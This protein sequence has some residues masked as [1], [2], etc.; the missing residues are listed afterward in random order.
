MDPTAGIW[1][2]CGSDGSTAAPNNDLAALPYG[3]YLLEE[4]PCDTNKGYDLFSDVIDINHDPSEP[5]VVSKTVT[6]RLIEESDD[7][8]ENDAKETKESKT[9]KDAAGK[10]AET[11]DWAALPT[12]QLLGAAA[13]AALALVAARVKGGNQAQGGRYQRRRRRK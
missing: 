5:S 1:F 13:L 6:N 2:G 10:L 12:T 4:L 7:G 8:P 3:R 11:G 9:P